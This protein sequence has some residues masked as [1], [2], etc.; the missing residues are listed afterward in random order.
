MCVRVRFF[1]A[2]ARPSSLHS[3]VAF[4]AAPTAASASR[5]PLYEACGGMAR[6]N[7]ESWFDVLCVRARVCAPPLLSG[8]ARFRCVL[9]SPRLKSPH[10]ALP[11]NVYCAVQ[12][13]KT[14]KKH[15]YNIYT[16][17]VCAHDQ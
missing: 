5:F 16:K 14:G 4:A 6:E 3:I 8:C 15:F 9:E 13:E 17:E 7:R 2:G 11:E 10:D 12:D 1:L